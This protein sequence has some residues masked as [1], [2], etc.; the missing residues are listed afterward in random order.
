MFT[1][2]YLDNAG[3]DTYL[4]FNSTGEDVN[5]K[6]L[7]FLK[8]ENLNNNAIITLGSNY[9]TLNLPLQ[10]LTYALKGKNENAS[11]GS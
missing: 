5:S 6:I 7:E 3:I 9:L 2:S 1:I 11:N 8:F 10:I 4:T